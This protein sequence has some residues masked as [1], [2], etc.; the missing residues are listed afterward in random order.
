MEDKGSC[1]DG[2]KTGHL[3]VAGKVKSFQRLFMPAKIASYGFKYIILEQL[4]EQHEVQCSDDLS[5]ISITTV[6][7]KSEEISSL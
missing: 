3:E 5:I 2:V 4:S 6:R 7:N 1:V